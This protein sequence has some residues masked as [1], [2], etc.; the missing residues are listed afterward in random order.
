LFGNET[1]SGNRKFAS[2]GVSMTID[3]LR[4][5]Y[6]IS[7][8]DVD[9]RYLRHRCCWPRSLRPRRYYSASPVITKLTLYTN[10]RRE[11]RSCARLTPTMGRPVSGPKFGIASSPRA[12]QSRALVLTLALS[13]PFVPSSLFLPPSFLS[14]PLSL[15][16]RVRRHERGKRVWVSRSRNSRS[17]IHYPAQL[18][19]CRTWTRGNSCASNG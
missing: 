9:V 10:F 13:S 16:S 15:R 1:Q 4:V 17:T 14:L 3:P 5:T 6:Y 2:R 19:M 7:R 12:I 18:Y 8:F 11:A